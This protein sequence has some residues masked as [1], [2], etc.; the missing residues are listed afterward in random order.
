MRTCTKRNFDWNKFIDFLDYSID[1]YLELNKEDGNCFKIQLTRIF[2]FISLMT[3]LRVRIEILNIIDEDMFV[4]NMKVI[5]LT[6]LKNPKTKV[7]NKVVS[8]MFVVVHL[9]TWITSTT[10]MVLSRLIDMGSVVLLDPT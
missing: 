7:I 8:M 2:E 5:V 10:S 6:Y 9:H 3:K 1:L 4:Q